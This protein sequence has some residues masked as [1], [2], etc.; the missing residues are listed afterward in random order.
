MTSG[1]PGELTRAF[2]CVKLPQTHAE[3]LG[4]WLD[5]RR[6]DC[7]GIRWVSAK[8]LH[9]TLKFCGE[10]ELETLSAICGL[11]R[12]EK[13]GGKFSLSLSGVGGFPKLSSPRVIWS[14]IN[15]DIEK[16]GKLHRAVEEYA[17]R[18][19]VAKEKKFSP[20]ITLGR[21][22]ETGA[23]AKNIVASLQKD[24]IELPEWSV[25]EIIMMK[26]ELTRDG[27]VYTPLELFSLQK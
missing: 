15:G 11:L 27:P 25:E 14:G 19:G 16:L 24:K 8:T 18:C 6:A 9:I 5:A 2:I 7:R 10:I 26:S 3:V 13:L 1:R 20:H 17:H 22:K 4:A 21:R 23:L 12:K